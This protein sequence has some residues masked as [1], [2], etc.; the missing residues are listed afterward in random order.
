[1]QHLRAWNVGGVRQTELLLHPDTVG[2]LG[3]HGTKQLLAL[4]VA[5]GSP[6]DR[7]A[8]RMADADQVRCH[9]I[10]VGCWSGYVL[11]MTILF[12]LAVIV[13]SKPKSGQL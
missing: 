9:T 10:D 12:V 5:M 6:V 11:V 3:Q 1:M 7:R 13:F 4:R 8:I 2:Y